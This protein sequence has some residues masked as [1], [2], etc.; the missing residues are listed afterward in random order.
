LCSR[1]A[2]PVGLDEK[3]RGSRGAGI[4]IGISNPGDPIG[5]LA[6][7]DNG[8]G[9]VDQIGFAIAP[10]RGATPWRSEPALDSVIAIAMM[11]SHGTKCSV[12]FNEQTASVANEHAFLLSICG[13]L[14]EA[15]DKDK[16]VYL[17]EASRA[18]E[19]HRIGRASRSHRPVFPP[20]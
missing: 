4:G 2:G 11:V 3:K 19:L 14:R 9:A 7:G 12:T 17:F 10:G 20:L 13:P 18:A 1:K 8:L 16:P 5:V 15:I 6:I